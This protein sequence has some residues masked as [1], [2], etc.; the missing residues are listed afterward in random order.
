MY[1]SNLC[2]SY[3]IHFS[4]EFVPSQNQANPL[5]DPFLKDEF[6]FYDEDS[7]A[8]RPASMPA[9][10]QGKFTIP[11]IPFTPRQG[12]PE[13]NRT[14]T[15][16]AA[17]TPP[18]F[19]YSQNPYQQ[20]GQGEAAYGY[21]DMRPGYI[22]EANDFSSPEPRNQQASIPG[23]ELIQGTRGVNLLD[24]DS[25]HRFL[26]ENI[27]RDTEGVEIVTLFKVSIPFLSFHPFPPA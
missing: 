19:S 15:S 11:P 26:I 8:E 4:P 7:P 17:L 21:G 18:D 24:L 1:P 25:E 3:L 20:S 27:D 22:P 23:L 5:R 14:P 9:R 6:D 10:R 2:L 12:Y 16:F 13:S